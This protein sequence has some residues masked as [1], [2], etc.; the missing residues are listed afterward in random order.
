MLLPIRIYGI[1]DRIVIVFPIRHRKSA[2]KNGGKPEKNGGKE[3]RGKARKSAATAAAKE[4]KGKERKRRKNYGA[5][6]SC[7]QVFIEKFPR[8]LFP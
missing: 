5:S 4:G 3:R 8:G 1:T 2:W 7:I 6:G